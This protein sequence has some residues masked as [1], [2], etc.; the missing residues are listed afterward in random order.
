MW[1]QINYT[2]RIEDNLDKTDIDVIKVW[3]VHRTLLVRYEWQYRGVHGDRIVVM[4]VQ[5]VCSILM[6]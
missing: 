6:N 3:Q 1:K 4:Q 5:V 2:Y